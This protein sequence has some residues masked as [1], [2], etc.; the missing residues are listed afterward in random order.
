MKECWPTLLESWLKTDGESL[1]IVARSLRK[2]GLGDTG[3]IDDYQYLGSCRNARRLRELVLAEFLRFG[4]LKS[5][6]QSPVDQLAAPSIDNHLESKPVKI[7]ATPLMKVS[8]TSEKTPTTTDQFV[9]SLFLEPIVTVGE[10]KP[11]RSKA[12]AIG[13]SVITVAILALVGFFWSNYEYQKTVALGEARH[14]SKLL[15]LP[16]Q[17]GSAS[18]SL[19]Q[20]A[21]FRKSNWRNYLSRHSLDALNKK[22]NALH[23]ALEV[24]SLRDF[25]LRNSA[26]PMTEANA[27][28]LYDL[29][30]KV[31]RSPAFQYLDPS[32][33]QFASARTDRAWDIQQK[34][35]ARQKESE[36]KAKEAA[37][38]AAKMKRQEEERKAAEAAQA[39]R[40][41]Q[42]AEAAE[43][44]RQAAEAQATGSS[45][46]DNGYQLGP[47]GGCFYWS[48][49]SKVYVDR[50]NCY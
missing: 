49:R 48:G 43:Q 30:W 33:Q 29:Y 35:I 34:V 50:S 25:A 37:E 31:R 32:L 10:P 40:D 2:Y 22:G 20:L 16:E 13:G 15:G 6:P 42:A 45:G 7:A 9:P 36:R 21:L 18:A 28:Q 1:Q 8:T 44:A 11:N 47:R 27:G 4:R 17:P 14:V 41:R 46:G 3:L 23:R 19:A 24:K 38:L 39:E 5:E 26:V 12:K